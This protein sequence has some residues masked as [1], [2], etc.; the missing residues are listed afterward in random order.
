MG[1]DAT[2]F[3]RQFPILA[4]EP[5]GRPLHYLDNAATSQMPRAVLDAVVAHETTRRANV[6]RGNHSLGDAATDAY[7]G[8]RQSVAGHIG[9]SPDE[10]VFT[11]G[12]TGALNLAAHSFG[13]LLE[14]GDEIVLSRLEHHSNLIPWQL[15]RDRHGVMLRE[16]PVTPEGRLD[17]TSLDRVVT[18]RCRLIALTHASN[19]TGA[20]T[21]VAAVVAA[22]QAVGARVLLDGAQRAPHGGPF[23]VAGL[24]VDFYAFSGHKMYAPN[25]IGVLWGRHDVLA[26][27]P[28]FLAGGHMIDRV[29][30]D[31]ASYAPPPLRFEAG[32]PPIAQAVGLG[33]AA[34]WLKTQ[35]WPAIRAHMDGLMTRMLDGLASLPGVRLV[36]P[37]SIEHRLPVFSLT[38]DGR[39]AQEVCRALDHGY[40]VALRSGHHC[41]QPLMDAFGVAGTVRASL[42]PY[43]TAED[44]DAFLDGLAGVTS[45]AA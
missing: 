26:E 2:A 18:P 35:D 27:M 3:R 11:S 32:T 7:D 29:R 41:A 28:P 24:G 31:R 23:D 16:I 22:A 43:N 13:S 15:L 14:S 8:A 40:G 12:A 38:V 34:R 42:L 36:G 10:V 4:T 17:L 45:R 33:A 44:V 21:D 30:W 20:I 1:F 37:A 6:F 39:E 19:V 5:G 25:G 9:V